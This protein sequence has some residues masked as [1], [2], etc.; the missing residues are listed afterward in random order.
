MQFYYTI[1]DTVQFVD[2]DGRARWGVIQ[3]I[4]GED[5]YLKGFLIEDDETGIQYEKWEDQLHW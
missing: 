5:D 4:F 1:G 3:E 2:D